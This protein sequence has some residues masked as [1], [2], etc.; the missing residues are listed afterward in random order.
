M[1]LR[2]HKVSII[3]LIM[4]TLAAL[5]SDVTPYLLSR[6]YPQSVALLSPPERYT[7]AKRT[8]F[9]NQNQGE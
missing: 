7:V 2:I 6:K 5:F 1:Y 4:P 8:I 9:E 3:I